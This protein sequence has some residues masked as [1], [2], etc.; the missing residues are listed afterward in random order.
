M[1]EWHIQPHEQ[2]LYGAADGITDG[3]NTLCN[4]DMEWASKPKCVAGFGIMV[5]NFDC[6]HYSNKKANIC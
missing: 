2:G 3:G 6:F 4:Y 5:D 1:E